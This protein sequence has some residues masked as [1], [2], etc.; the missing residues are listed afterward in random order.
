MNYEKIN[1]SSYESMSSIKHYDSKNE[2][3]PI[4][5]KLIQ[6]YFKGKILDL[7]CG[8]GRTTKFIHDQ[9]YDVIGVDIVKNMI[10]LARK[11][12]P[13]IKFE[14]GDAANLKFKS[15]EFDVVFF[16]FNG[17]DYIFPEVK[18]IYAI[19]EIERV[20]KPGGI[21]IFSSHDPQALKFR[22]RPNFVFRNLLK[23]S[24]FKRYKY[25]KETFGELY[26]FY[27]SPKYQIK[28]VEINTKLRFLEIVRNGR[29]DLFPHY[30]FLKN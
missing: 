26:T 25:E 21:F 3:K 16:S 13:K 11:K 4:E 22:F 18:R 1:A 19:K 10:D 15:G 27:G 17:L 20:L 2:I 5:A 14:V 6:K 24:L 30:V 23:R 29:K 28:S 9:G 12:F 8:T 7:G